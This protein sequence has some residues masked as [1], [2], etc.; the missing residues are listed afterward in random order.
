MEIFRLCLTTLFILS[1]SGFT[2]PW[3][4]IRDFSCKEV[5]EDILLPLGTLCIIEILFNR[6]SDKTLDIVQNLSSGSADSQ[7]S[8][9]LLSIMRLFSSTFFFKLSCFVDSNNRALTS[10]KAVYALRK[11]PIDSSVRTVLRRSI[12][13]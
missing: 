3:D 8:A 4:H 10:A 12:V 2:Y 11:G 6:H 13:D 7:D 9:I 5:L 1:A